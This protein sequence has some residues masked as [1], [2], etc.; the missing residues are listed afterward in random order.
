MYLLYEVPGVC[1]GFGPNL[2]LPLF[3]RSVSITLWNIINGSCWGL[4]AAVACRPIMVRLRSVADRRH[5]KALS[6]CLLGAATW[7]LT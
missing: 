3:H 2:C 7:A 4:F 6:K 1:P 5:A